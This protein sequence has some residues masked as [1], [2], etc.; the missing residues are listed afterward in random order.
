MAVYYLDQAYDC[1]VLNKFDYD[2]I[3]NGTPIPNSE[4][5][6]YP[7]GIG[8]LYRKQQNPEQTQTSETKPKI[9]V[10][11]YENVFIILGPDAYRFFHKNSVFEKN[12]GTNCKKIIIKKV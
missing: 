7:E 10:Y 4:D 8:L 3:L 11:N 12:I 6:G 5:S 2:V 9:K 1:E